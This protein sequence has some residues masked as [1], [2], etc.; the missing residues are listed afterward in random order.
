MKPI[1]SLIS[2]AAACLATVNIAMATSVEGS[3]TEFS[4]KDNQKFGWGVVDDGVM[5]G[6]S[7]GKISFTDRGT[8]VFRGDLSLENNGGFSSLR[9]RDIDLDL[10]SS[11]GLVARVKGDGRTYQMRLASDARYRGM[12]VSF[13]ADFATKKDEWIEVR[14][15]FDQFVGGWRG[16]SLKDEVF[17]PSTVQ[18]LGLILADKKPG[19]FQLEVDWLRTYSGASGDI[20]DAAL[21]DGRFKTLAAALTQAKLVEAIKG[22]QS[23][24]VCPDR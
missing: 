1:L 6:L 4:D 3:L 23:H 11:D 21:A 7:K 18:R 2:T 16:R 13:A 8:L 15:P 19:P 20:V 22:K 12:E 10:S 24:R 14:V 5:G 17:N 9:T